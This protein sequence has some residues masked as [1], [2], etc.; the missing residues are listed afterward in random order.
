[1]VNWIAEPYDWGACI[2]CASGRMS[3]QDLIVIEPLTNSAQRR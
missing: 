2:V 3:L 1:M